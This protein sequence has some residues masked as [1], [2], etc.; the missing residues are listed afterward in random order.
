MAWLWVPFQCVVGLN[1]GYMVVGDFTPEASN[2]E[3]MKRYMQ[4]RWV[5]WLAGWLD[6][7]LCMT[8]LARLDIYIA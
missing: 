3:C 7:H 1:V 8:G 6:E 4:C 2:S 5:G